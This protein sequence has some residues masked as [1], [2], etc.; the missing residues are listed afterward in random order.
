MENLLCRKLFR[1]LLL[2]SVSLPKS[3]CAESCCLG[4]FSQKIDWHNYWRIYC[5]ENFSE[6]CT[7]YYCLGC[8]S[9]KI[10]WDDYCPRTFRSIA[11]LSVTVPSVT[12]QSDTVSDGL[13]KKFSEP[14]IGEFI[15]SETFQET[16]VYDVKKN[17]KVIWVLPVKLRKMY[18]PFMVNGCVVNRSIPNNLLFT[19]TG[20]KRVLNEGISVYLVVCRRMLTVQTNSYSLPTLLNREQ[21]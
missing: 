20:Q 17:K 12:I 7:E 5:V 10:D 14:I 1:V 4:R 6:R 16:T 15:V 13:V 18:Y 21:E 8:S 19:K 2:C 9:Q 3:H 11:V